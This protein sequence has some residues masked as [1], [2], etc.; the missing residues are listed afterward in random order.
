M[1]ASAQNTVK[2][3]PRLP[4]LEVLRLVAALCVLFLHT[5]AVFGGARWYGRGYLAVDFF[6]MLSGYLM[7]RGLNGK[8]QPALRFMLRRYAR[9]WPTMA[10]G[11]V[12]GLPLLLI[13]TQGVALALGVAL[14]NLALIPVAGQNF[15]F[16]LNIPAW[17]IF[18]EL[19]A[20]GLHVGWLRKIGGRG[21]LVGAA[22]MAVAM[23]FI[24]ARHGDF[25]IGAKP[26]TFLLAAPRIF[27]AY[28][29]GIALQGWWGD[30]PVVAMPWWLAVALMPCL[31]P[32]GFWLGLGGWWWDMGFVLLGCPL[33][34]AGGLR[35]RPEADWLAQRLSG[36]VA[37]W[38]GRLAFPLFAVQMPVLQGM[39]YCGAGYWLGMGAALATAMAV[40]LAQHLRAKPITAM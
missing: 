33:M 26:A 27:L 12:L 40:T 3:S 21:A 24:A 17:T 7:A 37:R 16:P 8:N 25:D 32:L 22:I 11:S 39:R 35:M 29:L 14:A 10:L 9:L 6:L 4:G 15:V 1:S 31:L 18:F 38:A 20:N 5:R 2:I 19:V 28:G 30:R 13:K 34:L 36:R 23:V